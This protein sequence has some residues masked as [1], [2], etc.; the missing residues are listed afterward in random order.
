MTSCEPCPEGFENEGVGNTECVPMPPCPHKNLIRDDGSIH[1]FYEEDFCLVHYDVRRISRLYWKNC[2][3]AKADD[4]MFKFS[5][6]PVT[7][8]DANNTIIVEDYG[9]LKTVEDD[10]CLYVKNPKR[11]NRNPLV[12]FRDCGPIH[13]RSTKML[14]EIKDNSLWFKLGNMSNGKRQYC[15]PFE[16]NQAARVR[17]CLDTLMG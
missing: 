10:K 13:K 17:G 8:T 6:E 16:K 14:W 9:Y 2:E 7:T 11:L 1:A 5:F 15:V 3:E 4:A 12:R